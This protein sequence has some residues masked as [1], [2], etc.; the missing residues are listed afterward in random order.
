MQL[1]LQ[2]IV[3]ARHCNVNRGQEASIQHNVYEPQT[4][5]RMLYRGSYTPDECVHH[6]VCSPAQVMFAHVCM[7]VWL[8][9]MSRH[10]RCNTEQVS[11]RIQKRH[12]VLTYVHVHTCVWQVLYIHI[13]FIVA[14]CT[15]AIGSQNTNGHVMVTL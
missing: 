11:G 3:R 6:N 12:V 13:G 7:Y 15:S 8:C 9:M 5:V 2:A 14:S 10:M 1:H 4:A